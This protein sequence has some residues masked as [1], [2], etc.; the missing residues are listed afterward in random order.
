MDNIYL[1]PNMNYSIIIGTIMHTISKD[2]VHGTNLKTMINNQDVF[3][4]R[5][6]DKIQHK[7]KL[8]YSYFYYDNE[9]LFRI[10]I[11]LNILDCIYQNSSRYHLLIE[12]YLFPTRFEE[13][14]ICDWIL[15]KRYEI[16]SLLIDLL[17]IDKR[18]LYE[19][20]YWMKNINRLNCIVRQYH[21]DIA[22][23]YPIL[24]RSVR[25]SIKQ[26]ITFNYS[27]STYTFY[28]TSLNEKESMLNDTLSTLF[29][30]FRLLKQ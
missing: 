4:T 17:N 30:S 16:L 2:I 5:I 25:I 11:S 19:D 28:K 1:S 24:V 18:I 22:I 10:K 21:K 12:S 3:N 9:T 14:I 26:M 29:S 6:I 8:A 13:P 27:T 20:V 7:C 15:F 23:D